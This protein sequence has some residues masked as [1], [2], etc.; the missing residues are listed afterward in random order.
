MMKK[1]TTLLSLGCVLLLLCGCGGEPQLPD[2]NPANHGPLAIME[3]TNG[4]YYN[5]GYTTYHL[6]DSQFSISG[7]QHLLRYYDKG[8]KESILLCS[9]PECEHNGG[10][11]CVASY[12]DLTVINSVLYEDQI[13]IY[14][15]VIEDTNISFNLYRAS[16]DGSSMDKV[17]NVLTAQNTIGESCTIT[18]SGMNLQD[19]PFIIH[20]GYAYLP[21]YLR[22]GKA[23]KGFMGGGL[24]QMNLKTGET[25]TIYQ[26]DDMMS[27]FP[28]EV[29][30]CGDYIYMNIFGNTSSKG[31]M[32]Y[33]ISK[34][35]MEYP[36]ATA[37][38]DYHP[39]YHAVTE[40]YLYGFSLTYDPA[41]AQRGDYWMVYAFDGITGEKREDKD[42]MTDIHA[43]EVANLRSIFPYRDMLVIT[44]GERV[45]FYSIAEKT[46]GTKLGEI[47]YHYDYNPLTYNNPLLEYHVVNDTL[48]R[49]TEQP[50]VALHGDLS[51][52]MGQY[53]LYD[54]HACT[55]EE[56]LQGRGTWTE[57]FVY[58]PARDTKNLF[59]P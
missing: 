39:L 47:A 42:I 33:V 31:T 17:G 34:D 2:D 6:D 23:S 11:S 38:E 51:D 4:Y 30:G 41:T 59:Q 35:C 19:I 7:Y 49:I 26:L 44:T 55:L 43:D 16:P 46:Y 45:V 28:R 22:I 53:I 8:S 29:K 40:N 15:V 58:Q 54:V 20:R 24:M 10:D 18:P 3:T 1:Y 12:E 25:K 37:E 27:A 14:G 13:Y 56:I 5:Y 9:K 57:A 36:S 21:Y 32:R 50:A 48:Y 52:G